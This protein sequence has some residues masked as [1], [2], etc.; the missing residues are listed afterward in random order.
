MIYGG[1][2]VSH[3]GNWRKKIL[4]GQIITNKSARQEENVELSKSHQESFNGQVKDFVTQ[5][6][7]WDSMEGM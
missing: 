7:Q 6:S 5:F 4:C 2:I 1:G 3:S